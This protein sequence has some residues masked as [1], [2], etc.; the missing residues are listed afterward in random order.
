MPDEQEISS[1]TL[2]R[3]HVWP[4]SGPPT[5][6]W[7]RSDDGPTPEENSFLRTS[8]RVCE[9]F[10][11]ALA[12]EAIATRHA[13]WIEIEVYEVGAEGHLDYAAGARL[14]AGD[15][16]GKRDYGFLDI[17]RGFHEWSGAL[18][19]D[20]VLRAVHAVVY[21]LGEVRGWDLAAIDRARDAVVVG[22]YLFTWTSPWKSSPDGKDRVRIQVRLLDDGF[23][24]L[25]FMVAAVGSELPRLVSAEIV[26][27]CNS[28]SYES[29]A[30]SLRWEPPSVV[31]VSGSATGRVRMDTVT[32]LLEVIDP[33]EY[34]LPN[35]GEGPDP[36]PGPRI[37]LVGAVGM[38]G[39]HGR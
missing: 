19:A 12:E 26:A 30:Q 3:V 15:L 38:R 14:W 34:P 5:C 8:R 6:L 37:E 24:R 31:T 16:R 7:G 39:I 35:D 22:G 17:P 20:L 36:F 25:S 4:L 23:G 10:S 9:A 18:R 32:G 13:S 21:H 28:S 1:L 33:P 2:R 29:S 27:G 11:V